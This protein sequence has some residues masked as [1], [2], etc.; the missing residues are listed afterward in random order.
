MEEPKLRTDE[1][2]RRMARHIRDQ[3]WQVLERIAEHNPL[4]VCW[5]DKNGRHKRK[6]SRR[7]SWCAG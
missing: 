6:P 5:W 2:S 7:T 1:R 4:H 3:Q